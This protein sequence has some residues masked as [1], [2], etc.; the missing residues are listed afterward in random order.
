MKRLL[1]AIVVSML[2]P[3]HAYSEPYDYDYENDAEYQSLAKD[4]RVYTSCQSVYQ[5]LARF[6]TINYGIGSNMNYPPEWLQQ[7]KSL[8]DNILKQDRTFADNI[9][10]VTVELME[11]Y[12]F[13]F[14][15]IDAQRLDNQTRSTQSIMVAM[16]MAV[17]NPQDSALIIKNLLSR[18]Q[19]CQSYV[20]TYNYE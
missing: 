6:I 19:E 12:N 5:H 4:F 17:G 14:E 2:L 10:I 7:Q 13:A 1:L 20:S 15:D 11:K 3:W 18:S 8:L 16:T 9:V